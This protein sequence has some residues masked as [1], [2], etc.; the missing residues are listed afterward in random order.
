[1]ADDDTAPVDPVEPPGEPPVEKHDETGLELARATLALA[2]RAAAR[3]TDRAPSE[4]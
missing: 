4:P 3:R 2:D 1:M